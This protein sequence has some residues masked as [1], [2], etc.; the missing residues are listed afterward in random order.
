MNFNFK[1]IKQI[2]TTDMK[3]LKSFESH[4]FGDTEKFEEDDMMPQGRHGF[5]GEEEEEF[6]TSIRPFGGMMDDE[7]F[8]DED[9]FGFEEEE[10]FDDDEDFEFGGSD[11]GYEEEEGEEEFGGEEEGSGRMMGMKSEGMCPSCSSWKCQCGGGTYDS[12]VSVGRIKS[13]EAITGNLSEKKAKPDFLD[14]DKDGDKKE[15]MKKAAADKKKSGGKD[16]KED[17]K[18]DK[19]EEKKAPKGKL[20]KAQ[21]KLPPALKKA[22]ASGVRD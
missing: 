22:I 17:K 9:D 5:G 12:S 4:G 10:G 2:K 7:E 11:L 1:Y 3:H 15:S 18:E 8:E 16:S 19:K 21:E 13:F 20:S 14:L 6:E